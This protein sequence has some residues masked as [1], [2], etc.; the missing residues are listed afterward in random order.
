MKV[1]IMTAHK[2]AHLMAEYAKDALET[3]KPWELWEFR[4]SADCQWYNFSVQH[5]AWRE[6]IEYRRK[7]KTI[8][9]GGIDVQEPMLEAPEH[10]ATYYCPAFIEEEM[11]EIYIWVNDELDRLNLERGL[12]HA[13]RKAAIAH[14]KALILVSGGKIKE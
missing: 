12:V 10:G 11:V 6:D 13:T 1:K 7:H 9:I 8:N 4:Y 14:A 2:H 5:P 3:D